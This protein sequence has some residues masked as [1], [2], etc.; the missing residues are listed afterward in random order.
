MLVFISYARTELPLIERLRHAL[1]LIGCEVWMDQE[2]RGGQEWWTAIL[3]KI[4]ACDLFVTAVSTTTLESVACTR[5]RD[6]ATALG[7]P[8]L[9][10]LQLRFSQVGGSVSNREITSLPSEP[11][12]RAFRTPKAARRAAGNLDRWKRSCSTGTD[13]PG[14]RPRPACDRRETEHRRLHPTRVT[15]RRDTAGR[16][17]ARN[18]SRAAATRS[19]TP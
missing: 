15:L 11:T 10:V 4:R 1:E 18:A 2:I 13:R 17:S 16:R 3:G 5:E 12:R 9:P 7:K 6:Y 19:S 14:D 8:V